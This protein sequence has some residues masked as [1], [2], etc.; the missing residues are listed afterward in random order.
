M[1]NPV[2]CLISQ[3]VSGCQGET[4]NMGI[5]SSYLHHGIHI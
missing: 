4:T 3:S 2:S 5:L 1:S